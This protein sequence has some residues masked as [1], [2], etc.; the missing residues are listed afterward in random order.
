MISGN[1]F[2]CTLHITLGGLPII[3][4]TT[5]KTI[6]T[7]GL[8]PESPVSVFLPPDAVHGFV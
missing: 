5:R 1:G 8:S 3:A 2:V 6:A 7:M 4:C